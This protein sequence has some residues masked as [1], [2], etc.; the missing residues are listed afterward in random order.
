MNIERALPVN[1]WPP[2]L[3]YEVTAR[4]GNRGR[5]LLF[6]GR[7]EEA[8]NADDNKCVLKQFTVSHHRAAP[9][10]ENQGAEAAPCRGGQPPAVSGS[11]ENICFPDFIIAYVSI[12]RQVIYR[13]I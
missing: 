13:I 5:L 9:L 10:S 4:L 7:N 11:A 6:I 8:D 2:M 1:G 3:G 12:K